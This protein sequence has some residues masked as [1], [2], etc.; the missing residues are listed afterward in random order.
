MKI[1][2]KSTSYSLVPSAIWQI[3]MSFSYFACYFMSLKASE[4]KT[5][6][7][8]WGKY[9]SILHEATVR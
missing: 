7:E 5:E 4:R 8:K 2:I 3:C 9:L 1:K 6:Y